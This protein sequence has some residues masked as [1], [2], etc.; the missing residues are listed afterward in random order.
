ME[1][2]QTIENRASVRSF[3]AEKIKPED[4]KELVRR[5][6][7]AP[8]INNSQPWKFVVV[9]NHELLKK[10]AEA[11]SESIGNLPVIDKEDA[12]RSFLSRIEWYSTFFEDAPA[13]IALLMKPYVSVLEKGVE[14]SHDEIERMRNHPDMQT[15]G[16][17]VQTILLSAIDLGYGACWMS[18]PMIAKQA[19]EKLLKVEDPFKLV[20]FVAIGK[21]FG[22][23]ARKAKKALSEIIEIID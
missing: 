3:T 4:L 15:A 2:V 7:L 9:T 22:A 16:A 21:P 13:L 1:L 5:A 20:T 12:N 19:L 17:A 10:M 11:V 8:S 6:G 23:P 18:A 14:L